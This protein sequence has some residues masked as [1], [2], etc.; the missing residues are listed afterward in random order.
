MKI[1]DI[2]AFILLIIGGLALGLI[3]FFDYDFFGMLFG[4][5]PGVIRVIFA[6]IGLSAIYEIIMWKSHTRVRKKR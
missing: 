1:L 5:M 3:G 6:L 4:N 2:I